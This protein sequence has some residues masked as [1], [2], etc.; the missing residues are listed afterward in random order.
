MQ[1]AFR[2]RRNVY[3]TNNQLT[4]RILLTKIHDDELSHNN[5]TRR[6]IGIEIYRHKSIDSLKLFSFSFQPRIKSVTL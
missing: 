3:D 2:V 5:V 1:I 4:G 6:D